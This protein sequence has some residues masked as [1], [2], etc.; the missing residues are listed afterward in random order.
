VRPRLTCH[1]PKPP[2]AACIEL[3][4]AQVGVGAHQQQPQ[5]LLHVR[6]RSHAP[7]TLKGPEEVSDG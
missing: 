3:A 1:P 4:L 5:P 6:G 2:R 7:S